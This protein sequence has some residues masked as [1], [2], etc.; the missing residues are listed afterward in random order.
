MGRSDYGQSIVPTGLHATAISIHAGGVRSAV[1]RDSSQ[2]RASVFGDGAGVVTSNPAAFIC[3]VG[4]HCESYFLDGSLMSLTAAPEIGSTFAGWSGGCSG[5]EPCQ[6]MVGSALPV[7]VQADFALNHYTLSATVEG[8]GSIAADDGFTCATGT[9]VSTYTHG[10]VVSMSATPAKGGI[11]FA[12]WSGACGG[13]AACVVSMDAAKA[14]T[15]TF[16]QGGQK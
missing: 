14:V 2:V 13:T 15:A 12:G 11:R 3:A 6:I 9:C 16:V 8:D 1:L 10:T 7:Y 4:Q 5:L